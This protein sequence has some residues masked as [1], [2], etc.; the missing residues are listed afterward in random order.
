MLKQTAI[1]ALI[2]YIKKE[3]YSKAHLYIASANLSFY[4]DKNYCIEGGVIKSCLRD[5]EEMKKSI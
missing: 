1:L 2:T 3:L 4:I 5:S